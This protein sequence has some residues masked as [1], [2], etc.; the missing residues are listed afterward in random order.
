MIPPTFQIGDEVLITG[1]TG[2]GSEKRMGEKFKIETYHKEGPAFGGRDFYSA[3]GFPWYPASSL[4][5]APQFTIGNLVEVVRASNYDSR[6]L[7]GEKFTIDD[8]EG[9]RY[10]AVGYPWIR[11]DCLRLVEE[12]K[13]GD[14]VEVIGPAVGGSTAERGSIFQITQ[15]KTMCTGLSTLGKAAYLPTSLRKLTPEEI[16]QHT[17]P[18]KQYPIT[19]TKDFDELTLRDVARMAG[20]CKNEYGVWI[21]TLLKRA[22]ETEDRLSAIE[23]R[24]D[25]VEKIQ[26]GQAEYR[27]N[28]LWMAGP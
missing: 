21:S 26:R 11:A 17:N 1:P 3:R 14:W 25:F 6:H 20:I 18:G 24:L 12:L 27:R 16:K 4:Q 23:K 2:Y 13:I 15:D 8:I 5:L 7:V 22:H 19:P 28:M 9:D 10:T